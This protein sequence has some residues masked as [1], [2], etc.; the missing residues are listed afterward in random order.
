MLLLN[1]NCS[2]DT[3]GSGTVARDDQGKLLVA[4]SSSFPYN[5]VELAKAMAIKKGLSL[6]VEKGWR[7]TEVET[8]NLLVYGSIHDK[9]EAS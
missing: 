1:V 7:S 5:N 8:D 9:A 6:A 4:V 2:S 3:A